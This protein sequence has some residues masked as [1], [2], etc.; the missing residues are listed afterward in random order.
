MLAAVDH[1]SWRIT[2]YVKN[3]LDTQ[4]VLAPP[5]QP[6]Q[7]DNLTDDYVVNPP[8]EVGVRLAYSY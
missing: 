4:D 6:N 3:L 5:T 8:R 2:A 1:K 7:L